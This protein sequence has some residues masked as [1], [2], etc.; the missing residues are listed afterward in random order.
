MTANIAATGTL[1]SFT[2]P[3]CGTVSRHP[4][5][6]EHRYCPAC[7]WWTGDPALGPPHLEAPCTAR[8]NKEGLTL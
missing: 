4:Q 1:P 3:C 8:D 5:D 7:H 2:C 6:V